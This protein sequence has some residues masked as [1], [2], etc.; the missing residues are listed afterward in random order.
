MSG[1][2]NM[3]GRNSHINRYL[4]FI[5]VF[6]CLICGLLFTQSSAGPSVNNQVSIAVKDT[7]IIP[8]ITDIPDQPDHTDISASVTAAPTATPVPEE[9]KVSPEAENGVWTADGSNWL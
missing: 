7:Q 2:K 1:G 4:I 8:E 9:Q 5:S 3:A 6:L